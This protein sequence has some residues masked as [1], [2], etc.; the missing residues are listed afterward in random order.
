MGLRHHTAPHFPLFFT[1]C[2]DHPSS[3]AFVSYLNIMITPLSLSASPSYW[4]LFIAIDAPTHHEYTSK[5]LSCS[6][7]RYS[8][9]LQQRSCTPIVFKGIILL[10]CSTSKYRYFKCCKLFCAFRIQGTKIQISGTR[11]K[12]VCTSLVI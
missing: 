5:Y 10:N 1:F 6:L 9:G 11:R 7:D 8:E 12:Q 3:L 2:V 4:F